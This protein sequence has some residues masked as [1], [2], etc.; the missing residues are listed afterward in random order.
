MKNGVSGRVGMG[1]T[2]EKQTFQI[3][4]TSCVLLSYHSCLST[5]WRVISVCQLQPTTRVPVR[6]RKTTTY[7]EIMRARA[8]HVP[9]IM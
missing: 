4:T 2:K 7:R 1:K 9:K 5:L 8:K 6:K 3:T